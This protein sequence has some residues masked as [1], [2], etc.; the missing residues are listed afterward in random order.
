MDLIYRYSEVTL[1]AADAGDAE[2]CPVS[3]SRVLAFSNRT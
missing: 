2:F 1:V 3:A